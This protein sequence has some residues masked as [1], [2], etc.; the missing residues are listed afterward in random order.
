MRSARRST[1]DLVAERRP[2]NPVKR[3]LRSTHPDF[4]VGGEHEHERPLEAILIDHARSLSA[5]REKPLHVG[6]ATPENAIATDL[7]AKRIAFPS[8]LPL[9]R[10][11]I[12]MSRDD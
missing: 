9:D 8:R 2:T 6:C 7:D 3:A 1:Q 10:N 12:E 5:L 11:R 4:L